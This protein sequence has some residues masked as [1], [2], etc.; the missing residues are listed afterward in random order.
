MV[1]TSNKTGYKVTCDK[2]KYLLVLTMYSM[3]EEET[4]THADSNQ[5]RGLLSFDF[6]DWDRYREFD[7]RNSFDKFTNC[8]LQYLRC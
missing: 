3:L 7:K 2:G 1:K 8:S 4:T 5:Q 6:N